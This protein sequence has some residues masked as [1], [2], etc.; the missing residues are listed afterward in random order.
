MEE[1]RRSADD[2]RDRMIAVETGLQAHQTDCT[3]FREGLHETIKEF[4]QDIKALY[5]RMAIIV[6]G[7]IVIGKAI[8]FGV[9]VL[10][11]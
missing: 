11:R 7:L 5:I 1:R 6:G 10:H 9:G 4:R 2:T 8:D 3:K